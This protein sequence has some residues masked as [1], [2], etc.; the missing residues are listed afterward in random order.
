MEL[1]GF[2][3]PAFIDLINRKIDDSDVRFWVSVLICALAGALLNYIDTLF[4][5][6]TLKAGF[7][8][9]SESIMIVFGIAQLSYKALWENST[10]R[11]T[12]N[13]KAE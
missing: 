11:E 12:L 5:F 9:V 7:I 13:L 2:L 1:L 10:L 4:V 8:S 6:E 3:L